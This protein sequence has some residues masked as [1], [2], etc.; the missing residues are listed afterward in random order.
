MVKILILMFVSLLFT[1][2]FGTAFAASYKASYSLFSGLSWRF[3]LASTNNTLTLCTKCQK[4]YQAFFNT[5]KSSS[6]FTDKMW[7]T[8]FNYDACNIYFSTF[9]YSLLYRGWWWVC[10]GETKL[11]FWFTG[12]SAKQKGL[13]AG[14]IKIILFDIFKKY[15]AY[16]TQKKNLPFIIYNNDKCFL[17]LVI[18]ISLLCFLSYFLIKKQ[19]TIA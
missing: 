2:D 14:K 18:Y 4:E 13:S 12:D 7:K 3:S 8:F 11:I 17:V 5:Q 1:G 6:F 10:L 9:F 15:F 16:Q 19:K